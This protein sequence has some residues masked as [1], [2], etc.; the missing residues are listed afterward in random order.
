M[1]ENLGPNVKRLREKHDMTQEQLAQAI[2]VQPNTISKIERNKRSPSFDT[3]NRLARFFNV[4]PVDLLGSPDEQEIQ[5]I[6]A[7]LDRVDEYLPKL[8]EVHQLTHQL[9]DFSPR[10]I[11]YLVDQI[12]EIAKF[13]APYIEM[14]EDGIPLNLDHNGRVIESPSHYRQLP[15]KEIDRIYQEIEAIKTFNQDKFNPE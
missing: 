14:D 6:P 10:Q 13:F 9:E 8:K 5:S 7:I 11:D 12:N 15:V 3:L 2:E 1:I 4:T